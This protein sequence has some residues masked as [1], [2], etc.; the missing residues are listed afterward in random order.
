MEVLQTIVYVLVGLAKF[1]G[2]LVFGL[3]LGWLIIDAYKKDEKSWQV[4]ATFLVG[5]F[6]FLIVLALHVHA[7]LAGFG[8]GIGIA[9]FLWGLPKKPKKED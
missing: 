5:L 9:I 6:A 1:F 4:Q 8:L 2:L 3:G 7:G